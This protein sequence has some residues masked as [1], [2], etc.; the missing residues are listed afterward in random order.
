MFSDG[1][2]LLVGLECEPGIAEI[3]V[4]DGRTA[5][6]RAR[7]AVRGWGDGDVDTTVGWSPI[8]RMA[9]PCCTVVLARILRCTAV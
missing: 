1:E 3:P 6:E 9:I 5:G 4:V 7:G 2:Y 8:H